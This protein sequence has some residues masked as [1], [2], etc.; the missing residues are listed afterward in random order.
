[1]TVGREAIGLPILFLTVVLLG[2]LRIGD[3]TVLVPPTVFALVLGV[4][5]VRVLVQCGAL[6]PEHLVG[7]SRSALANANG[8]VVLVTLWAAGS[9][10]IALVIPDSGLPRLALNVFFLVTLLNTAAASPD[11]VRLLRS[12]TVTFGSAFVLKFV[13]LYELSTPG[14]SWLKRVLQAALEGITLGTLTQDPLRPVTGYIAFATVA[15]FLIGIFLLPNNRGGDR[16]VR[17][18]GQGGQVL[19]SGLPHQPY[20]PRQ[21]S[22]ESNSR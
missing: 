10:A 21:P 19:D 20:L 4:L 7:G 9:Q 15:S 22:S 13:V 16:Q 18:V 8:I 6:A 2:G 5:L 17:R 11:R 3:A 12:L 14:T 1:M